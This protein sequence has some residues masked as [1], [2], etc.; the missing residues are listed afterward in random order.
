MKL[1]HRSKTDPLRLPALPH[2]KRNVRV[3]DRMWMRAWLLPI[4]LVAT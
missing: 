2:P 1:V 4:P 3:Y